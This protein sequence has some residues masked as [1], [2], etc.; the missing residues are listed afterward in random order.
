MQSI[1][2]GITELYRNETLQSQFEERHFD[3][4]KIK[5]LYQFFCKSFIYFLISFIAAKTTVV[6]TRPN[7][8]FLNER[9]SSELLNT[10]RQKS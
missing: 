8:Q 3:F 9:A 4:W 1:D 10:F 6:M 5:M 7:L 2:K